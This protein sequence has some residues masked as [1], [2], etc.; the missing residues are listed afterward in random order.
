[1]IVAYLRVSTERQHLINQRNE[2]TKFA[3]ARGMTIDRWEK[4]VVSG[5]CRKEDRNLGHLLKSLKSGDSLI[6]TE[7]SRLSRTLYD[8]MSVLN[9]CLERKITV[10]STKDG[11]AFDDSINSKVLAFAFGW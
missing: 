7:L 3:Q 10:Y 4:E 9:N 6:V 1:M 5:R 8:I 2:I 11:Y